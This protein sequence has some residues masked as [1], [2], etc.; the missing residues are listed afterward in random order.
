MSPC[1]LL[2]HTIVCYFCVLFRYLVSTL[3]C[4]P[5]IVL[6]FHMSESLLPHFGFS[7]GA[8]H[9]TQNLASFAYH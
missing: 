8:S 5:C 9:S 1:I 4:L 3:D 6:G 7:D 2:Y